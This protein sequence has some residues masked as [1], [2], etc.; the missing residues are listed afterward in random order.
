M[1]ERIDLVKSIIAT[2][3]S[4]KPLAAADLLTYII[5]DEIPSIS[6]FFHPGN[7]IL[8][9]AVIFCHKY[10]YSHEDVYSLCK[11]VEIKSGFDGRIVLIIAIL[12][13]NAIPLYE[14]A[15]FLDSVD[16]NITKSL[17]YLYMT[18]IPK[19]IDASLELVKMPKRDETDCKDL[20]TGLIHFFKPYIKNDPNIEFLDGSLADFCTHFEGSLT[21][22]KLAYFEAPSE[23][24]SDLISQCNKDELVRTINTD[25]LTLRQL[26][27]L[28]SYQM[29]IVRSKDSAEYDDWVIG[30]YEGFGLPY[31]RLLSDKS[32]NLTFEQFIT[33]C[34]RLKEKNID[35]EKV[36]K[37][38]QF[39]DYL[40]IVKAASGEGSFIKSPLL[41]FDKIKLVSATLKK[42]L[43]YILDYLD[44]PHNLMY[45]DY[46]RYLDEYFK[47]DI[48][49]KPFLAELIH[50]DR[51][52]R[53]SKVL[54][55]ESQKLSDFIYKNFR[56]NS[57]ESD[58]FDNMNECL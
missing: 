35:A 40:P 8:H 48:N 41:E 15:G 29:D 50:L 24:L 38:S 55:T 51:D 13:I 36:F 56:N 17:L 7:P 25:R 57:N 34:L 12:V 3:N 44:Q 26:G 33:L 53:L 52:N 1:E 42:P 21:L 9:L 4:V 30:F 5:V 11:S 16:D 22:I 39:K 37:K 45:V 47:G 10:R 54:Q 20:Y 31:F 46:D 28:E 6:D 19:V 32:M 23:V 58:S 18:T 49:L 14:F 43:S 27:V 2:Y